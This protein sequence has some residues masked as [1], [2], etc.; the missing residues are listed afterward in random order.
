MLLHTLKLLTQLL[1]TAKLHIIHSLLVVL[2]DF[3][4]KW[5]VA[6]SMG[7]RGFVTLYPS[8]HSQVD[9]HYDGGNLQLT[10]KGGS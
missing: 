8:S 2:P 3:F 10:N 9:F 1:L 7:E 6:F 4:K 5:G